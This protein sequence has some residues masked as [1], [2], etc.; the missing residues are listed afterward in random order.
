MLNSLRLIKRVYGGEALVRTWQPQYVWAISPLVTSVYLVA[1][2]ALIAPAVGQTRFKIAR[3]KGSVTNGSAL[4]DLDPPIFLFV[5]TMNQQ[6]NFF[7][8]FVSTR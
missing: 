8:C 5:P 4:R 3:V 7:V 1:Q 2:R 6:N